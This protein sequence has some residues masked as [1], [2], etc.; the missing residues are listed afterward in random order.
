MAKKTLILDCDGVL[1][2]NS[3][4]TLR[5]FVDAMKYTCRYEA[6]ID[7]SI[8]SHASQ[9]TTQSK[10][11]GMFNYIKELCVESGYSFEKFCHQMFSHIDYGKLPHDEYLLHLILNK[12]KYSDIAIL[13]NN[14]MVHL[15]NVVQQRFGKSVFELE[16][17]GITCYDISSTENNGIFYPKQNPE[18]LLLFANRIG[19]KP[20]DCILIDDAPQNIEA[21]KHIGMQ[22]VLIN[23]DYT[24]QKYLSQ[25]QYK[26]SNRFG[27]ENG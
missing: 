1:Y 20:Q 23:K 15:N 18:A 4:I 10:R 27:R 8:Q 21:G 6:K 25:S 14:H 16:A 3:L 22:G 19:K 9:L 7:S 13:T 26:L 11:F 5:D 2:S 12:K 17:L 24:L